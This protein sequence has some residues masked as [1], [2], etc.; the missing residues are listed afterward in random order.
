[1]YYFALIAAVGVL[2]GYPTS[3][4]TQEDIERGEYIFHAAGCIG[5]HTD[6]KLGGKL[7]A[8]GRPLKTEFGVFYAPN[9]TPDI[10]HGIGAW[11]KADFVNALRYGKAPDG[12]PYFPSFPYLSYSR[13][14]DTDIADLWAFVSTREA[15]SNP[16]RKHE[17]S[18]PYNFRFLMWGWRLL[19]FRNR[20]LEEITAMSEEWNRGAYLVGALSHCGE[21]HTP[22]NSLGA[23]IL[24]LELGGNPSGPL[25]EFV[26]NITPDKETGIGMWSNNEIFD[27]IS[28][29]ITPDGDFASGAMTEVI[30][31][32]TSKLTVADRRAIVVYLK[33]ISAVRAKL[34]RP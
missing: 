24:E 5:C 20:Q 3:A 7:L 23:V 6:I 30:N 25:G 31:Q 34:K 10:S 33:S 4:A 1:M 26:A 9:I 29:G 18:F 17:L 11:S 27:Y 21:C 15:V 12:T 22:R 13:M 28:I 14:N 32:T 16:N 19:F 8:G 2:V